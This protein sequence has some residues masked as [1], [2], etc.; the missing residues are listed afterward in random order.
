MALDEFDLIRR[1]FAPLATSPSALGLRDDAAVVAVEPASELVV[2]TDTLV[3]GVHFFADDPAE[4]VGH[5]LLA[6]NLSDLAAMGAEPL[7]YLLSVALPRH[8]GADVAEAWLADFAR[9]VGELQRATGIA[10]IGGDTVAAPHDLTLG[11]TALGRVPT[12]GALQ[13]SGARPG[14]TVWVSGTIGDG[15]LGLAVLRGEVPPLPASA[16]AALVESYRRPAPRLPLG[17]R[18]IGLAS[19]AA[20]ISDGLIADLGHICGAS[21]V[22]ARLDLDRLPLSE[23]ALAVVGQAPSRRI[24]LARGGDDYELVFTAPPAAAPAIAAAAMAGAVAVTEV[25][26][27]TAAAGALPEGAAAARIEVVLDGR[28]VTIERG[29][30]SHF[31]VPGAVR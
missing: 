30:Y 12:G 17:R 2:T 18:L 24:D 9:G 13:R 23:A 5:K 8:W 15:A 22:A 19:A 1:H 25:G 31:G 29:G 4:T 27:I 3:A 16:A 6:V 10:L 20:D 11:L 7:A 28:P 21:G 26:R 14:D